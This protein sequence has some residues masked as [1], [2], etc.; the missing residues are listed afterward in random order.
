MRKNYRHVV[1]G[2]SCVNL[3]NQG[4][5]DLCQVTGD[6]TDGRNY[7]AKCE[8]SGVHQNSLVGMTERK[9]KYLVLSGVIKQ[10]EDRPAP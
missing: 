6:K 2:I 4:L 8:S 5:F 7:Q 9:S 3:Y 1:Y 10:A